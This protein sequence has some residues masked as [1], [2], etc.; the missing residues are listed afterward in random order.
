MTTY[1]GWTNYATWRINLEMFDGLGY[2]DFYSTD[3]QSLADELRE[4]AEEH[5]I[6]SGE[7]FAEAY[8]LAFLSEVNWLEIAS[9]YIEHE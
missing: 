7:G 3:Q 9:H 4:I 2:E 8:A 6:A 1:N 5:I